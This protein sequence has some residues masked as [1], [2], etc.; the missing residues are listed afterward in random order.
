MQCV[1][2]R[3]VDRQRLRLIKRWLKQERFNFLGYTFG[4]HVNTRNGAPY[5]GY[6][7]S[8]KSVGRMKQTVGEL[9]D[10]RNGAPWV[11]SVTSSIRN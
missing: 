9:L 7:P 10:R 11:G 6:S 4:P 2:R 8:D 5:L 1:A 3:I